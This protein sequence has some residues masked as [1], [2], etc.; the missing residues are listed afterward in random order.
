MLDFCKRLL[1]L[2][3]CESF[4]KL[5]GNSETF[6]SYWERKG[7]ANFEWGYRN[8]SRFTY[9]WYRLWKKYW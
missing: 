4:G 7:E 2:K 3:W 9:E 8:Y 1:G 6:R 5:K